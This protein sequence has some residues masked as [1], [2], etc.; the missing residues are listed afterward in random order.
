MRAAP[1]PPWKKAGL[2][3]A[4]EKTIITGQ[5]IMVRKLEKWRRSITNVVVT[6]VVG[7]MLFKDSILKALGEPEQVTDYKAEYLILLVVF[8]FTY[9]FLSKLV[10]MG[11]NGSPYL[12]KLM[13]GRANIEGDWIAIV[14][15]ENHRDVVSGTLVTVDF[16]GGKYVVNGI[17]YDSTGR[18][19]GRFFTDISE[20]ADFRLKFTANAQAIGD[21]AETEGYGVYD[22]DPAP[23]GHATQ[24][25]GGYFFS[26]AG[27]RKFHVD[28]QTLAS[29]LG[30][31]N[32][33][34]LRGGAVLLPD[35]RAKLV[36]EYINYR[37]SE[38]GGF[39]GAAILTEPLPVDRLG[40]GPMPPSNFVV[41]GLDPSM[42][43][44]PPRR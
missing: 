42:Q 14:Y 6:M 4:W 31:L 25:Y 15:D 8:V 9:A 1:P 35:Q 28:G 34:E 21:S 20:Y 24:S 2:G 36:S 39:G 29:F 17:D 40:A 3:K 11:I 10:E 41:S 12:R 33:P 13:M 16:H 23:G 44:G 7:G 19:I 26:N 27:A 18:I 32:D 43:K 37:K 5:A 38:F 30:K 22:F